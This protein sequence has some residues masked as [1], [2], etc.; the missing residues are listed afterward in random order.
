MSHLRHSALYAGYTVP[1][2]FPNSYSKKNSVENV[3]VLLFANQRDDDAAYVLVQF[4]RK[5]AFCEHV[6]Y[7]SSGTAIV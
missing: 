7:D 2:T 6:Q 1:A 3:D 5:N 4:L